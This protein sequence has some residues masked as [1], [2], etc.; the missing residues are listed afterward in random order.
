MTDSTGLVSR[1]QQG[2]LSAFELLV[3]TYQNRI[4]SHCYRLTGSYDDAQD[5]AQEVF[6]QA[7]KHLNT[8]R[9]DADFGTWLY[10]I[11]RNQWINKTRQKK[12]IAISS[13][14]SLFTQNGEFAREIAA[15]EESP[16]EKLERDEYYGLVRQALM[17][18]TPEYR[19]VLVL[20][21][22]EGYTY[23]E[24][25]EIVDCS[26]GTVKSR[27]NRARRIM[28]DQVDAVKRSIE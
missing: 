5:L 2:D 26:L 14:E 12:V 16:L 19:S 20:R 13:D 4:F 9:R 8:F 18:L 25:A 22:M 10:K 7:Y 1:A 23:E 24:I 11:A 3:E 17:S 28:R 21:D 6:I 27:L 15:S